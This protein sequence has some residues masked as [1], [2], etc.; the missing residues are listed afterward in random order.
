MTRIQ[1]INGKRLFKVL[2][3]SGCVTYLDNLNFALAGFCCHAR[4]NM[5]IIVVRD[6]GQTNVQLWFKIRHKF[7]ELSFRKL[8]REVQ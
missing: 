5:M 2:S 7:C 4:M 8:S 6:G 3:K 1:L